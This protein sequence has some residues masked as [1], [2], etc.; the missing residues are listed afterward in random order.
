[1]SDVSF[2]E[3]LKRR[4]QALGLTQVQLALQIHCSASA[5]RKFES[6]ERRPSAE[7]VEQLADIFSVP[8]G[9]RKSFLRFARGDWQV[10]SGGEFD[11][12]PWQISRVVIRS[13]LPVST[14]SFIG[15]EKEQ[16]IV[17][18][19]IASHRF[20]TLIGAG[21]IG[22]TRLSL[23]V[24]E[25][26]LND[27]EHG[28]WF[29]ELASLSDPTLVPHA[30]G[31]VFGMLERSDTTLT[32]KLIR[33]LQSKTALL[34]LDN[35]E[36]LIDACAQLA[37]TL[38][39]NCPDLKILATSREALGLAGAALYQVPSLSLPKDKHVDQVADFEAIRLFTDRA[40]LAVNDFSLTHENS[41]I[42][43]DICRRLDGIPL[44]IELAAARVHMLSITQ[45]S[46]RLHESFKF[47]ASH[48]R[49][50][51]AR[52]Q[53]LQAS[54]EW[55]WNLLS[56]SESL[57][58]RRLSVFAGGWTLDAAESICS[59]EGIESRDVLDLMSQLVM[60]SLVIVDQES[61]GERRYHL[62]EMIRQYAHEKLTA[63]GSEEKIRTLHLDYFL[64]LSTKAQLELRGPSWI[65][66]M[67][68]L[69]DERHNLRAALHW[70]KETDIEAG[71]SLS[72]R[73]LRYW[74]SADMQEGARW[75]EMLLHQ[76]GADRFP[77]A[78]AY[79]LHAYGSL[80]I[81]LQEFDK[82]HSIAQECL[83]LFQAINDPEGQVDALILFGNVFMFRYD[84]QDAEKFGEQALALAQSLDD[85][86][87]EATALLY[88]GW[89]TR[90]YER[91]FSRWEKSAL[92]FRRVGDEV[93]LAN[94]LGWLGHFRVL[95][96][97]L[98]L[99]E[100]YLD[101]ATMLW[102]S[103]KMANIWDNTRLVRSQILLIRG[104]FEQ[105]RAILEDIMVSAEETGNR[106]SQ[107]W[108]KLR[109]GYVAL[110]SGNLSESRQL[111]SETAQK[112]A[113]DGYTIGTV[114]ALEGMAGLYVAVGKPTEAVRLIGW[115]DAIRVKINDP[116]PH[117]EQADVDTLIAACLA[118]M[119]EV[120]F[121]NAYDEGRNMSLEE[122]LAFAFEES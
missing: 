82:A 80:L 116:R 121:S 12:A 101:E 105:A 24:G 4:R 64:N 16:K 68:R 7:V 107:L 96:G 59:G 56:D 27:F 102:Q 55:S 108:V 41:P 15:R 69:N 37:E 47:L 29:V 117:I 20:V 65:D 94:I 14:T 60:K 90:N 8:P 115:A 1:M 53:T 93:S 5:L 11:D 54:I 67:E 95:N 48:G 112:F 83:T 71:L 25:Q 35:C 52:Q 49:A 46:T 76:T 34:I 92:L 51:L 86:W 122:A 100:T 85:P 6:E 77:T 84:P 114:F 10:M 33:F 118:K 61:L 120:A 73:L 119:G 81:W 74:E 45:I 13:N 72:A 87:R 63:S 62:L 31:T 50:R 75:L 32:E 91:M 39:L 44:A 113:Q 103:N 42:V 17:S 28:V 2:G 19:L 22:K 98:E 26:I 88:L 79:A 99:A 23:K 58:L 106:M 97:D 36:H 21:G 9:E 18:R 104:N 66:W 3:W 111:L 43:A 70:A 110:R 89:A 57:L 109:I 40:R 78:K 38:L 30:V